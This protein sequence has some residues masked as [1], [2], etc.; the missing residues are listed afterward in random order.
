MKLSFLKNDMILYV[1]IPKDT[2]NK[3]LE[4]IKKFSK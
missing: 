2:T 4:P 1:G 3:L